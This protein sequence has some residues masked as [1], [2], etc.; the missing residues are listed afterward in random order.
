MAVYNSVVSRNILRR[1]RRNVIGVGRV[2]SNAGLDSVIHDA[3]MRPF[4]GETVIALVAAGAANRARTG[5]GSVLFRPL[6]ASSVGY[7]ETTDT[8]L[9]PAKNSDQS[10][11][12]L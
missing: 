1:A 11:N 6:W 10:D 3:N 12:K 9:W 4:C 7:D 5:G 2:D 8:I